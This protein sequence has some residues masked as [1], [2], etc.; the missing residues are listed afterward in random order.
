MVEVSVDGQPV[1][2][3]DQQRDT[4]GQDGLETGG[5]SEVQ[6][7]QGSDHIVNYL[8]KYRRERVEEYTDDGEV[9][10]SQMLRANSVFL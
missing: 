4:Q 2:N 1:K 6:L 9:E 7:F 8:Y 3:E 10:L 5:H